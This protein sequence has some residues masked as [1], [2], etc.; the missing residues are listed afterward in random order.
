MIYKLLAIAALSACRVRDRLTG[1]GTNRA[2]IGNG[3]Y[4]RKQ[5][6]AVVLTENIG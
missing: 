1:I 4:Y 3:Q 6:S 2:L 5:S